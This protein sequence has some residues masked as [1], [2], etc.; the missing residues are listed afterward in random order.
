MAAPHVAGTVAVLRSADP[1]ATVDE[2]MEAIGET[3]IPITD[4][5]NDVIVSRVQVNAAADA[6]A[7]TA[8]GEPAM[9]TPVP[10][11][12]LSG[13]SET[14]SW[15][16]NG[17]PVTEWSIYIGS[18]VGA[19]DIHD[20]GSLGTSLSTTIAGLP[21]DGS[22]LFLRLW[23]RIAGSWQSVDYQYTAADS[24]GGGDQPAMLTPMPGTQLSG[25]SETFSWTATGV[26]VAKWWIHIGSSVGASDIHN[27]GS[28]GTSLSTT[29]A[30]LPTDGSLLYL[31]L[32]SKV[33]GSWQSVD[34]Q[35][36]AAN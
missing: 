16:A 8:G 32:W 24:G 18:S 33:A 22:L 26:R 11:T 28:L 1:G 17:A 29:I 15:D 4:P 3:G 21:T 2:I 10:G 35:Y 13:A 23:F 30:G 5:R 34:Y 25:A 14:F 36:T 12:Q 9:L 7:F 19:S 20:S 27:S 6:L 31:R